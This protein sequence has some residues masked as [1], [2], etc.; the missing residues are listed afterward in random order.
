M[1]ALTYKTAGESHGPGVVSFIEGL[2]AGI[3]IDLE[4]IDG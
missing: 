1:T 3:E 4:F 2:P